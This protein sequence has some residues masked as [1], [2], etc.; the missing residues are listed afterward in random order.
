MLLSV[1][2]ATYIVLLSRY[3]LI[4]PIP[5]I[6]YFFHHA[7][8]TIAIV[9]IIRYGMY[10]AVSMAYIASVWITTLSLLI[11]RLLPN[12]SSTRAQRVPVHLR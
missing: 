1:L 9:T 12:G 11:A 5:D 2:A 8:T 10:P 4:S 3:L 7:A 6:I